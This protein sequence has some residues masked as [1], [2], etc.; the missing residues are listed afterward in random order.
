MTPKT[1]WIGLT[2]FAAQAFA[3]QSLPAEIRSELIAVREELR[4]LRI[5][6]ELRTAE[7]ELRDVTRELKQL[8]QQSESLGEELREVR[9]EIAETPTW[10]EEMPVLI[11]TERIAS[12]RLAD[13]ETRRGALATIHSRL[14]RSVESLQSLLRADNPTLGPAISPAQ[15]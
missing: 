15:H 5:T 9:K 13:V 4:A 8:T 10:H 1:V 6:F 11:D 3:Q 14:S 12:Q 7:I 2:F